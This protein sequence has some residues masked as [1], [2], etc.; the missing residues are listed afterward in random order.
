MT[1]PAA[2]RWLAPIRSALV[3]LALLGV[4]GFGL[5]AWIASIRLIARCAGA[6]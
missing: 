4:A 3:L 2:G 1:A 6:P 5:W